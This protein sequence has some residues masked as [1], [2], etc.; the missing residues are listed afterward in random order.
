[1]HHK[2]LPRCSHSS[3]TSAS[4]PFSPVSENLAKGA[5][6][7]PRWPTLGWKTRFSFPRWSTIPKMHSG[8]AKPSRSAKMRKVLLRTRR[9]PKAWQ[10][11][12]QM[13]R[14]PC[15]LCMSFRCP[16]RPMA[17][18][19]WLRARSQLGPA[20][21]DAPGSCCLGKPSGICCKKVNSR[22]KLWNHQ[23]CGYVGPYGDPTWSRWGN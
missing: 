13:A 4:C 16:K 20:S 15:V 21:Q 1:M 17:R 5:C 2:E 19:E 10:R 6:S 7:T 14:A 3:H 9:L 12:C 23:V 22:K 8:P 11:A 18:S